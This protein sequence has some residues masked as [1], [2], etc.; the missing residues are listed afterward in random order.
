MRHGASPLLLFALALAGCPNTDPAVFVDAG[1]VAPSATVTENALG[2]ALTGGFQLSLHLGARASDASQVSVES[3]A[4]LSA[5][6]S[7]EIVSPLPATA[8][9]GVT[10]PV[11]VEPDS[12]ELVPFTFENPDALL[13]AEKAA[14]LCGAGG[15]RIKVV[16]GD[17]LQGGST[18][19]V[20]DVF[21]PS[22]P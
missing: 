11:T 6:Q 13:P 19:V 5:D 15:L 12:D 16:I 20:S 7:S 14:E 9:G 8:S 18:P 21:Q 1:I 4:I 3:F 10:F 2:V 17:S 22:C